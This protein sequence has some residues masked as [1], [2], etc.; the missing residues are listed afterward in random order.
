[1]DL[2]E[3]LA[4]VLKKL[5]LKRGFVVSSDD[6]L[7]EVSISAPTLFASIKEDGIDVNR[8]SPEDVGYNLADKEDVKGGN[9]LDNANI[10]KDILQGK[11]GA[12]RD[13]ACLNAG[14]AISACRKLTIHEGVKMA[15]QSIDS[16][17]AYKK[18]ENL[19][20]FTNS[21]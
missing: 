5:G 2:V 21:V 19:I 7:D 3:K 10:I 11:S 9:A 17:N 15:E 8:F 14:F 20:E 16:G 1:M 18:L 13:I 6:G 4:N 12:M